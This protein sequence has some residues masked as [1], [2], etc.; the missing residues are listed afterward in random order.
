MG[1]GYGIRCKTC[2]YKF[3][4][5]LG[6]GMFECGFLENKYGSSKACFYDR[7]NDDKVITDIERL[8]SAHGKSMKECGCVDEHEWRGHG[9]SP[10]LCPH[11]FTLDTCYYFKLQYPGGNYEPIYACPNCGSDMKRIK[12]KIQGH[13]GADIEQYT[14]RADDDTIISF[15]DANGEPFNWR[16]PTCN[17][18]EIMYDKDASSI[19][20]D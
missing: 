12:I 4:V 5:I 10:Y 7:I 19:C 1:S 8:R 2:D 17:G 9:R 3:N 6:H 11:C 14:F 18:S 13:V 15:V 20:F 16:C